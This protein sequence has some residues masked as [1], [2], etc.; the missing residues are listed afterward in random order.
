MSNSELPLFVDSVKPFEQGSERTGQ[1]PVAG[2]KRLLPLLVDDS[3]DVDVSLAFSFDEDKRRVIEGRLSATLN[4]ECQRCLESMAL[5]VASQFQVG[6][7]DSEAMAEQ[8]PAELEPVVAQEREIDVRGLIEDELIMSLPEFPLH[9]SGQCDATATLERINNSA[10]AD[11]EQAR[12]ERE[13]P[14]R[15]ALAGLGSSESDDQEPDQ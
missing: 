5:S 7:V 10:D 1:L 11:F 12:R 13:N 15:E 4:V 3:G 8:L 9:E 2:F 6:V 14:F